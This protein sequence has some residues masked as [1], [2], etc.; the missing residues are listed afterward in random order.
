VDKAP[1]VLAKGEGR[2]ALHI[3]AIAAEN[4]VPIVE[5]KPVARLLYKTTR[6]GGTIPV[7]LFQVVAQILAHVYRT[8]RY[9]FYRL[10][11]RR[12]AEH[13]EAATAKAAV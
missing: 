4:G 12:M 7:E 9:F 6:V 8:H 1:V 5:N 2:V 10:K 11:A 13:A 3:K